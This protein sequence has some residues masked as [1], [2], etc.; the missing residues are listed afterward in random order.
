LYSVTVS[1][2]YPGVYEVDG[3]DSANNIQISVSMNDLTFTL[4]G[5][6]YQDVMYIIVNGYGGNDTISLISPDG[7]GGIAAGINGGDGDDNITINFDGGV[8]AGSGNDVL[9]LTDSYRGEAQGDTGDDQIFISGACV[10]AEIQG[11]DG[12]D[13]IDCTNSACGVTIHGGSGNDTIF[14]SDFNDQIWGDA[15]Y[16]DLHGGGGDDTFYA[17]DGNSDTIDGGAGNDILYCDSADCN[18]TGIEQL[19][20]G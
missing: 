13:L 14:G 20:Y 5:V 1:E 3:D 18:T 2:G 4:D 7:E 12:N 17:N 19:F 6:T 8:Y 16:D 10:D 11:G 15:G 9:H